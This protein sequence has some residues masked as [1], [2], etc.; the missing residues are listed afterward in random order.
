MS[1]FLC[2]CVYV[3]PS[4]FLVVLRQVLLF[5]LKLARLCSSPGIFFCVSLAGTDGRSHRC[6]NASSFLMWVP[7]T[8]AQVVTLVWQTLK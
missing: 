8:Q 4:V 7:G 2:V 5:N 3:P 6:K 1:V